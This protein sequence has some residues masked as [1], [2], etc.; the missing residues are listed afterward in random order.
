VTLRRR[1]DR[2]EGMARATVRLP[3]LEVV[4]W[5][6]APDSEGPRLCGILRISDG[7]KLDRAPEEPEPAFR[8]RAEAALA[9]ASP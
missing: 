1:L 4:H 6:F 5:I 7:L 3:V 8:N 9:H 2:L